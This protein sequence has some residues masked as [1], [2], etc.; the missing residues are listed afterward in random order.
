MRPVFLFYIPTKQI[1]FVDI[2]PPIVYKKHL[3]AARAA[4]V[5]PKSYKTRFPKVIVL[6][7][8]AH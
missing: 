7:V 8:H 6:I 4:Q 5:A 2:P 3:K 1:D